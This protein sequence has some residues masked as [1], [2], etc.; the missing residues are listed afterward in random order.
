MSVSDVS[1]LSSGLQA[2]EPPLGCPRAPEPPQAQ[3]RPTEGI[4][5]AGG[6]AS[7]VVAEES[8]ESLGALGEGA[9]V[10]AGAQGEGASEAPSGP[11]AAAKD[12]KSENDREKSGETGNPHLS[13]G[14]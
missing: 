14:S 3:A 4:D 2:S 6:L 8:D 1:T 9:C 12:E 7:E 13:K 11:T 5:T 10:A